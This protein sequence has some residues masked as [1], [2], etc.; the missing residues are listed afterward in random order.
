MLAREIQ[1]MT[2]L[3]EL[4]NNRIGE[5]WNRENKTIMMRVQSGFFHIIDTDK[6]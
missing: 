2:S 3:G 4:K 1:M 5:N 6:A